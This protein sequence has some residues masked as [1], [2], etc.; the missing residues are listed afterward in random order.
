MKKKKYK[1]TAPNRFELNRLIDTMAEKAIEVLQGLE[2][3]QYVPDF[4]PDSFKS[5]AHELIDEFDVFKF[6][7]ILMIVYLYLI[8]RRTWTNYA[9]RKQIEKQ[10]ALDD[11]RKKKAIED[12]AN[13][14]TPEDETLEPKVED[15][16]SWGW[17]KKSR[18]KYKKQEAIFNQKLKELDETV[19]LNTAFNPDSDDDIADLLED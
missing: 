2:W 3:H 4:L 18:R 15:D 16:Q 9:K 17:G 14:I 11:L 7:R 13:G 8:L 6:F 5:A 1:Q 19:E 12:A 10:L